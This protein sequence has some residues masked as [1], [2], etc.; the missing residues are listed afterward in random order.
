[1]KITISPCHLSGVCPLLGLE[2][3]NIDSKV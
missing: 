1:V 2:P 3:F